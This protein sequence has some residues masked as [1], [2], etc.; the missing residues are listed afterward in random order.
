M[1]YA[2]NIILLMFKH[3]REGYKRQADCTV[4]FAILGMTCRCIIYQQTNL[5]KTAMSRT[6]L[7]GKSLFTRLQLNNNLP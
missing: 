5:G 7:K 3:E 2:G 1:E 6:Q 4:M